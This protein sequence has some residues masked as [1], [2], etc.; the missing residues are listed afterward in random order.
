MKFRFSIDLHCSQVILQTMNA[1]YWLYTT[2]TKHSKK[3]DC[4]SKLL[5]NENQPEFYDILIPLKKTY[6]SWEAVYFSKDWSFKHLKIHC[7]ATIIMSQQ[8][9]MSSIVR[10]DLQSFYSLDFDFHNYSWALGPEIFLRLLRN[11]HVPLDLVPLS[12]TLHL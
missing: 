1:V 7:N 6:V 3:V 5:Q 8:T 9:S 11:K 4:Q 10:K 12:L 2:I